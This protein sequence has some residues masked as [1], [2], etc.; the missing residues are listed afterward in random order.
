MKEKLKQSTR[1]GKR[2]AYNKTE[3][4]LDDNNK[5]SLINDNLANKIEE[6]CKCA[7]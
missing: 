6:V 1:S 5:F 2:F 7:K 3:L 4:K